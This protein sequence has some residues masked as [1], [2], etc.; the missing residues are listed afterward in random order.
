MSLHPWFAQNSSMLTQFGNKHRRQRLC[1][2]F[3]RQRW[4]YAVRDRLQTEVPIIRTQ[5]FRPCQRY[6]FNLK[7]ITYRMSDFF[8]YKGVSSSTCIN[9][10]LH[11][12]RVM[13]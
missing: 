13:G 12:K 3:N 1:M 5:R 8:V 2:S 7:N 4:V 9:K 6:W 10:E 11:T